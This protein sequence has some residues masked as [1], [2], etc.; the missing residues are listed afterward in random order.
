MWK[1]GVY[2]LLFEFKEEEEKEKFNFVGYPVRG[3]QKENCNVSDRVADFFF[4][5]ANKSEHPKKKM[6]DRES[7]SYVQ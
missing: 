3:K 2:N 6:I 4:F 7:F 1:F 5:L